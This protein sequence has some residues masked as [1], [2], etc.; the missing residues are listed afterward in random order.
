MSSR[1]LRVTVL[2]VTHNIDESVYLGQRVPVM[3]KNPARQ[4]GLAHACLLT[5]AYRAISPYS[6]GYNAHACAE[7]A[8]FSTLVISYRI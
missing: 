2:F 7:I 1:R 4:A 6:T 5:P 8:H 3:S